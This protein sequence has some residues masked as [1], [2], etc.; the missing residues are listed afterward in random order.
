MVKIICIYFFISILLY[1]KNK[2][3]QLKCNYVINGIYKSKNISDRY[4][5]ILATSF[6]LSKANI[7]RLDI[8][9]DLKTNPNSVI[10][11]LEIA[12][13]IYIGRSH[14]A[15]LWGYFVLM[16]IHIFKPIFSQ[17]NNKMLAFIIC[18]VEF[19]FTYLI[20][21]YLDTTGIGNKILTSLPVALNKLADLL[22]TFL[23]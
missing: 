10:E 8:S 18:L 19:F 23:Y 9:D 1:L 14:R 17:I 3:R 4:Q 2:Y 22:S 16:R 11:S 7:Y 13:G 6:L 21:L 5:Y 12:R 20:G 15:L